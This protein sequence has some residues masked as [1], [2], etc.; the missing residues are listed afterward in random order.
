MQPNLKLL[1][2]HLS[3]T[4]NAS[5][6][7]DFHDVDDAHVLGPGLAALPG[8][9]GDSLDMEAGGGG[10]HAEAGGG[11]RGDA[12]VG[13]VKALIPIIYALRT[14]MPIARG[15]FILVHVPMAVTRVG[16]AVLVSRIRD[17]VLVVLKLVFL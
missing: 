7:P 11:G 6:L 10:V 13:L 14:P 5:L 9:G 8:G 17:F 16:Q 12:V 15:S 4:L 2:L 1:I 3:Q